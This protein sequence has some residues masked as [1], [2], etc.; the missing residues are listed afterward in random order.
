MRIQNFDLGPGFLKR[1][2]KSIGAAL[3][4]LLT[5]VR[6]HLGHRLNITLQYFHA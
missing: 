4:M 6:L 1:V 3:Q 2:N 5:E